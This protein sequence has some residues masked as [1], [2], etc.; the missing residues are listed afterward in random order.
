MFIVWYI[1]FQIV[2][3]SFPISSSGHLIFLK[4]V[5]YFL[6]S[7]FSDSF[8]SSSFDYV[9][10]IPTVCVVSI[11]FFNR[12]YKYFCL[13]V[14]QPLL[15]SSLIGSVFFIDF[16]T[17]IFY[18]GK[19]YVAQFFPLWFGFFVTACS[20]FSL[21]YLS[22]ENRYKK[23]DDISFTNVL[24]IALAQAISLLPGVSRFGM[25]YTIARWQGLSPDDSFFYSFLIALPLFGAAGLK[26]LVT[27]FKT[28]NAL[29]LF[30]SSYI[31]IASI[32]L[33]T[34]VSYYS[35]VM[36]GSLIRTNKLW[37]ISYYMFLISI[38]AGVYSLLV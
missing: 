25:T 14:T 38:L 20:L 5:Y 9:L 21:S 17:A 27:L 1:F 31:I 24:C 16:I 18:I 22:S 19:D 10:H 13:L 23:I 3:E 30:H 34:V 4:K 36:V 28:P 33:A 8:I 32:V 29:S 35:F 26:G 7:S 2:G 12:L 37:Y 15:L 6:F 11:Y